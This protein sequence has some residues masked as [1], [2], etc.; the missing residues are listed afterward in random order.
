MGG[1]REPEERRARGHIRDG[2]D[3]IREKVASP[4]FPIDKTPAHF[5][6]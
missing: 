6:E 2:A 4:Q 1:V 3:V 5:V